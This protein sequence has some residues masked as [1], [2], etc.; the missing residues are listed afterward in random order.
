MVNVGVDIRR[1]DPVAEIV[2]DP[3]LYAFVRRIAVRFEISPDVVT[4]DF[5]RGLLRSAH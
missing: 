1:P 3:E 4:P 5:V 2:N